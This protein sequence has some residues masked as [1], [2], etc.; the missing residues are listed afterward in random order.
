MADLVVTATSVVKYAGAKTAN[1]WAG[2]TIIAGQTLYLDSTTGLLKKADDTTAAKATVV[3]IA[4]NG[5]AINQ[6]IAYLTGGGLNPGA[7]VTVGLAYGITDTAGGI[8]LISERGSGDFNT[9]LGFATTTSRIEVNIIK[10]GV[11]I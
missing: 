10:A 11:A 7:A 6:P 5:G 1:G 8:A 4:L 9:F 3:G 2:E